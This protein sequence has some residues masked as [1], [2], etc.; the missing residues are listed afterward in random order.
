MPESIPRLRKI[1]IKPSAGQ[2][3]LDPLSPR[4]PPSPRHVMEAKTPFC[5]PAIVPGVAYN[6]KPVYETITHNSYADRHVSPRYWPGA[7][8]AV[9]APLE[10]TLEK[11]H[12]PSPR[13]NPA[14]PLSPRNM[15]KLGDGT[16]EIQYDQAQRDRRI[17][18]HVAYQ[19]SLQKW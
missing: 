16:F 10:V 13:G 18:Y 7:K 8:R 15:G 14:M 4:M 6:W 11:I 1:K 2:G 3:F 9:R 17:Y 19:R 5:K 12:P